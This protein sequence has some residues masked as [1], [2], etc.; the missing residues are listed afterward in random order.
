MKTKYK[1][2]ILA[3]GKG[4]RLSPLTKVTSKQLLPVYDKPMIFYPIETLVRSGIDEILIITTPEDK[5]TFE[6]LIGDGSI[7]NCKITFSIQEKPEGIAQ[8]FII[9]E[10]WL[11]K[12]PSVLILGDNI[13]LKGDISN[14]IKK[15]LTEN[16]GATI[17]AYS[18]ADPSRYGVVNF[19]SS[20]N[21]LGI[22]EKPEHPKSNW[23]VT[24]LYIYNNHAVEEVRN[25]K[26]SDR[27]EL[28]ITDLNNVF[29]NK[30]SI[31]VFVYQRHHTGLM[32]EQ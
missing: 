11:A 25:L 12:S 30:Y 29:L 27:G 24:G 15:S 18:V 19:D 23:A 2:I 5:N 3:G 26:P 21:V 28:E 32:Q 8:A 6:N 31:D 14:L 7:F 17:F 20:G 16:N 13:F 22:E 10:S 9:A 1:G 4:T